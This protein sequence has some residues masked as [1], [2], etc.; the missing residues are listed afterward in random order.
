MPSSV[1]EFKFIEMFEHATESLN[2]WPE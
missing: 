1:I 2:Y